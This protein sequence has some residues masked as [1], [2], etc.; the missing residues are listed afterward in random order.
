MK[1]IDYIQC[2]E[3][4]TRKEI[5]A[6][7]KWKKITVNKNMTTNKRKCLWVHCQIQIGYGDMDF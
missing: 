5:S 3:L 1:K 2:Y 7:I 4:D 6:V